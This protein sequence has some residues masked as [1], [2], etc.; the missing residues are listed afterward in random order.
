MQPEDAG[1][2]PLQEKN[3]GFYEDQ[4]EGT[5]NASLQEKNC[6]SHEDAGQPE[7]FTETQETGTPEDAGIQK[8]SKG[9]WYATSAESGRQEAPARKEMKQHGHG[10]LK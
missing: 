4:P 1:D 10:I 3:G 9:A 8:T 7:E 5:G 2:T 6:G